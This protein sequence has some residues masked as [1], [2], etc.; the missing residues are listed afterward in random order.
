[1]LHTLPGLEPVP[2]ACCLACRAEEPRHVGT[3][4][5]GHPVTMCA[6]CGSPLWRRQV[7]PYSPRPGASTVRPAAPVYSLA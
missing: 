6:Q 1:M 2:A 3:R 5:D 4:H 7:A